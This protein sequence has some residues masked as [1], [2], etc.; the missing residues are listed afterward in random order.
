MV[1]EKVAANESLSVEQAE[2]GLPEQEALPFL[3]ECAD[4]GCRAIVRL[5][6]AEYATARAAPGRCVCA[7]GHPHGGRIVLA[8]EGYVVVDED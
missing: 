4:V 2:L 1:P 8:G 7:T 5:T 6:A 3:C